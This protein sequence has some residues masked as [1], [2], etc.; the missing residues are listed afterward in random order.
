MPRAGAG[1]GQGARLIGGWCGDSGTGVSD[2]WKRKAPGWGSGGGIRGMRMSGLSAPPREIPPRG[3]IGLLLRH[4]HQI[5]L[6]QHHM[7]VHHM[8]Q[9]MSPATKP[10]LPST[11]LQRHQQRVIHLETRGN[12]V[13]H[14]PNLPHH[15]PPRQAGICRT[16]GKSMDTIPTNVHGPPSKT[17]PFP[18]PKP[19]IP[20][21]GMAYAKHRTSNVAPRRI[22]HRVSD[23]DNLGNGYG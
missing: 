16:T 22:G 3:V 13:V 15:A 23:A 12:H 18:D 1:R 4:P 2:A 17:P 21:L 19:R 11:L 20:N 14:K 8:T 5:R 10:K 6:H 7:V 9:I